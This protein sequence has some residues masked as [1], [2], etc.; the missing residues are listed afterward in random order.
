MN[1]PILSMLVGTNVTDLSRV[2]KQGWT[3]TRP[4]MTG[5][6]INTTNVFSICE[7]SVIAVGIDD[8]NKLYSVTIE[9]DY[10]TWV[11][12]CQLSSCDVAFGDKVK[13]GTR[14]GKA[15]KGTLRFEYCSDTVSD[16]TVRTCTR[17]LYKNDPMV[18]LE[19]DLELPDI[20]ETDDG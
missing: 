20:E 14:I 1:Y 9:Y 8:K 5:C 17:Q 7:G 13:R 6:L 4:F 12:Y 11:R 2:I 10:L 3:D 19:G 16:F 15:Y 18:I